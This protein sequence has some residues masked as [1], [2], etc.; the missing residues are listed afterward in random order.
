MYIGNQYYF[1]VDPATGVLFISLPLRRQIW[2]VNSE[3][4]VDSAENY[5]VFVGDGDACA[6]S[7]LNDENQCGDNDLA[8]NAKLTL[9]KG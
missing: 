4:A 8:V 7:R 5:R 3:Y 6:P 9:P 2:Q 1:A